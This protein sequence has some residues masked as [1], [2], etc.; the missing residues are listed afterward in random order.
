MDAWDSYAEVPWYSF[1]W[2]ITEISL[3]E[4]MTTVGNYAFAYTQA[5]EIILPDGV[6]SVG[7]CAFSYNSNLTH[8]VIPA[9]IAT[10]ET[11][12][13]DYGIEYTVFFGVNG[14]AS[15]GPIGGAGLAAPAGICNLIR[16]VIFF[17][18]D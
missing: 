5:E 16:P 7:A 15:A 2:N 14:L 1:R 4:G 3:P 10:M 17:A 8:V 9:S 13:G 18:I 12:T 6:I 11:K